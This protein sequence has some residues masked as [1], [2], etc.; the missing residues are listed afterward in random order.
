MDGQ[1]SSSGT[2]AAQS[3]QAH[4]GW[5]PA[6]VA[7]QH[8]A[9]QHN[10]SCSHS[11][12]SPQRKVILAEAVLHPATRRTVRASAGHR[13]AAGTIS[14]RLVASGD[15]FAGLSDVESMTLPYHLASSATELSSSLEGNGD[16]HCGGFEGV[17]NSGDTRSS[18]VYQLRCGMMPEPPTES[19]STHAEA[20]YGVS[21]GSGCQIGDS[22]CC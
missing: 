8:K 22:A 7:Q 20:C 4:R 1:H 12:H 5:H 3:Q 10:S 6:A 11:C 13:Q 19:L 15:G 14:L 17:P 21:A 18:C 9:Q 16:T 2:A